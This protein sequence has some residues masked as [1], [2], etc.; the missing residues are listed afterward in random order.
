MNKQRASRLAGALAQKPQ[1]LQRLSPGVYRNN[2]GQ[3]TNSQGQP[4]GGQQAAPQGGGMMPQGGGYGPKGPAPLPNG[5]MAQAIGAAMGGGMQRP[6]MRPQV[7]QPFRPDNQ[8][9]DQQIQDIFNQYRQTQQQFGGPKDP[10]TMQAEREA[11][12]LQQQAA[13]QGAGQ[14]A[15]QYATGGFAGGMMPQGGGMMPQG[16]MP[17]GGGYGQPMQKQGFAQQAI[18]GATQGAAQG[19]NPMMRKY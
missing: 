5:G 8:Q 1:G 10:Q 11:M 16:Q 12:M 13:A 15:G 7:G 14:A 3:L 2:Q 9:M 4:R 17:Q 6:A 18:Q 19:F